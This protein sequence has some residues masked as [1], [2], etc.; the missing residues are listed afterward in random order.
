MGRVKGKKMSE[1]IRKMLD[2]LRAAGVAVEDRVALDVETA[3]RREFG[4][5][6]VY[7]QSLPK[8]RRAVQLAR[9]GKQTDI[10]LALGSGLSIRHIRRIRCGR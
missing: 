7:V 5:E 1:I 3:L 10:E 8:Q 9:L 4:G 2:E 6:R